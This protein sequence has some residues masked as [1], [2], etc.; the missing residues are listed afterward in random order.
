MDEDSQNCIISLFGNPSRATEP[1]FLHTI[2]KEWH[3]LSVVCLSLRQ[4]VTGPV[5]GV[6]WTEPQMG[7]CVDTAS[8]KKLHVRLTGR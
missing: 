4:S 1:A 2:G 8:Q 6:L 7:N 5:S 3:F